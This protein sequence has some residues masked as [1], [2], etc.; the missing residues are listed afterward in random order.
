MEK[1][2]E[3]IRFNMSTIGLNDKAKERV[4]NARNIAILSVEKVSKIKKITD[5]EKENWI[6]SDYE[7][8]F[9]TIKR[10]IDE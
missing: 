6:G 10:I 5:S 9:E 8:A 3:E 7:D 4:V 2:I 1:I